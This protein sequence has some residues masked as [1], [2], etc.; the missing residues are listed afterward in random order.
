MAYSI[1]TALARPE[2]ALAPSSVKNT[3]SLQAYGVGLCVQ[4]TFQAIQHLI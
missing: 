2:L 1:P 4:A 3:V